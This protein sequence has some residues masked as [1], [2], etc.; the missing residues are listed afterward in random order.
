MPGATR[1]DADIVDWHPHYGDAFGRLNREWLEKYFRVEPVDEPV[2]RVEML[3]RMMLIRAFE[4]SL[5]REWAAGRIPTSA[6][7]LSIGQ[8]AVAVGVCFALEARDTIAHTH[9]GHGH[10][11]AKGAPAD[12]MMAEI[13]GRADGLCGGKG[14]SMHVTD[15]GIGAI[16]ANGIVGASLSQHVW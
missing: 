3:R 9:R 6:I 16:G 11:L 10:M 2:L 8:E 4:E 7:H 14:G 1:P 15:A 5:A 12:R 13:Y